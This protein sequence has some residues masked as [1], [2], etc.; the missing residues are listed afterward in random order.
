[1]GF[2]IGMRSWSALDAFALRGVRGLAAAYGRRG[3]EPLDDA[4]WRIALASQPPPSRFA[5]QGACGSAAAFALEDVIDRALGLARWKARRPGAVQSL[6]I[7]PFLFLTDD[8]PP[9]WAA[10]D[11]EQ[12]P[13]VIGSPVPLLDHWPGV[14]D[15]A[16]GRAYAARGERAFARLDACRPGDDDGAA[17][18]GVEYAVYHLLWH[19]WEQRLPVGVWW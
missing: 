3:G 1:M 7:V 5:L 11:G 10:V 12:F 13:V 14:Y 6:W 15:D 4:W 18:Y 2:C 8:E 17:Y 19:A 9:F 16:G